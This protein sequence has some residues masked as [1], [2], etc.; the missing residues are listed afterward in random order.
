VPRVIV[1]AR[2]RFPGEAVAEV[3]LPRPRQHLAEDMERDL[4]SASATHTRGVR[5]LH[6]SPPATPQD[7]SHRTRRWVTG[8]PR[9]C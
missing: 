6:K 3:E 8:R 9:I 2:G 4:A 1:A 5:G 7:F